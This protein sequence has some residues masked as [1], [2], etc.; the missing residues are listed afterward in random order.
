GLRSLAARKLGDRVSWRTLDEP[1]M[2]RAMCIADVFVLPSLQEG[3]GGVVI[4]AVLAG[5]PV[6]VHPHGGAKFIL[7]DDRWMQDLSQKGNLAKRLHN[8]K[9]SPPSLDDLAELRERVKARFDERALV[10]QFREMLQRV[11]ELPGAKPG[12]IS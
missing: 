1:D 8:L 12:Y 2:R 7:Q 5:V 3:L 9:Q 4:E 6:V 10:R 11:T